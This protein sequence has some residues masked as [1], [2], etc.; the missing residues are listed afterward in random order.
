MTKVTEIMERALFT[1]HKDATVGEVIRQLAHERIGWIPIVDDENRLLAYI[2]DGDIVRFISHKRPRFFDYGEMIAVEVDEESFESKI[3][4]LLDMPA[5]KVAG[6][7]G[8]K[9][10][11]FAEVDQGI[12]EVADIFRNE[13]VDHIAVL[14]AGRVVGFVRESD[15]VRHILV[16]FLPEKI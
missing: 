5:M 13:N 9:R 14:D 8:K 2:T 1:T 11:V 7:A 10:A 12:D 4:A 15:I 6:R 16:T 3:Q